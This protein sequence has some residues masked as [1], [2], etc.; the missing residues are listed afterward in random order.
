M[1]DHWAL[2]L[3]EW[4]WGLAPGGGGFEGEGLED[5][6]GAALR[7]MRVD[8]IWVSGVVFGV[9]LLTVAPLHFDG[10]VLAAVASVFSR[11]GGRIPHQSGSYTCR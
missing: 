5:G 7:W 11:G 9:V 10:C 8:S 4:G 2:G 6:N 1:T 3:G